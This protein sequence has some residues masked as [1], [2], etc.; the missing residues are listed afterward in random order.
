MDFPCGRAMAKRRN[1]T[2]DYLVYLLARVVVTFVHV[3]GVAAGYRAAKLLSRLVYRFDARHR[4]RALEHLRRSFPDWSQRHVERV[5]R[6]SFDGLI[7]LGL[8]MLF[9]TRLI[10]PAHWRRHMTLSN[11]AEL[12]EMMVRR[13]HGV[14]LVTGHFG[15]WEVAGYALATLGFPNVSVA[16]PL[17]NPYIND[18]VLGVRERTGQRILDKKGAAQLIPEILEEK[19][20][21]CFIADQDPGRKGVFVEFFGR[22]ASTPKTPALLAIHYQVPI[23]VTYAK[24]MEG[25]FKFEVGIRRIIRPEQWQGRDDP[26]RWITHEYTAALEQ[27][28][29]E[30]PGQ[31]NWAHRRWKHRPR[32]QQRGPDGIA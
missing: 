17:N 27:I 26:V 31:Y 16:R 8:E 2:L 28:V 19:G 4:R 25:A 14:I 20:I 7:Y 11:A 18:F 15:N 9:T 5:A 13:R 24:R 32:G 6:E 21:L 1:R 29:R 22:P 10:T 30:T 3:A 23:A 12:V